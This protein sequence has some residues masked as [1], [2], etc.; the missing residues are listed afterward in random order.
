MYGTVNNKGI[1]TEGE[2]QLRIWEFQLRIF[3][4]YDEKEAKL[5][6]ASW[7]A[8]VRVARPSSQYCNCTKNVLKNPIKNL[9]KKKK[10]IRV[11]NSPTAIN[12]LYTH[13]PSLPKAQASYIFWIWKVD[14]KSEDYLK[15]NQQTRNLPFFR[16]VV[17]D[18]V[19]DVIK[20]VR[21]HH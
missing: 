6:P 5:H 1:S 20:H 15:T 16:T 18:N 9:K 2:F 21:H 10:I 17:C 8:G 4:S 13:H 7:E 3:K 14:K 19:L 11:Y 12:S